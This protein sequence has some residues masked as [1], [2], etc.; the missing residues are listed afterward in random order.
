M[1]TKMR[2]A[3]GRAKLTFEQLKEDLFD[4]EVT[5]NNHP[6]GLG[7]RRLRVTPNSLIFDGDISLQKK[8]SEKEK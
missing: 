5:M 1:K 2:K 4:V 8:A 3:V 6:P 7:K